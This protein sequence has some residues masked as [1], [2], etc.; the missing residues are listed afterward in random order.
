MNWLRGLRTISIRR[1]AILRSLLD[2]NIRVALSDEDH[3]LH[4]RA[5]RWWLENSSAGWASCA[6]TQN[7]FVRVLSLPNYPTAVD[8]ATAIGL[9]RRLV[10]TTD[11]AAWQ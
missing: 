4:P 3:V 6:I 8:I 7:G 2:V 11:H 1:T 5:L 9:L 10:Q